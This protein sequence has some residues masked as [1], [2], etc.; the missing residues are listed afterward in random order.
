MSGVTNA[1]GW[2]TVGIYALLLVGYFACLRGQQ[3]LA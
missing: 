2:S 3:S 1:L